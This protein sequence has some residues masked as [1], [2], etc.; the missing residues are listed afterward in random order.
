MVALAAGILANVDPLTS[1]W[2]A[3][4]AFMLG[5]VGA[6]IWAAV[7]TPVRPQAENSGVAAPQDE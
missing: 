6:G 4:I 3:A 7:T 5:W 1:L 2:R